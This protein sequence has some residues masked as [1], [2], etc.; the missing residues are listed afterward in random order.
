MAKEEHGR[1]HE[2]DYFRINTELTQTIYDFFLRSSA[3]T[4][5]YFSSIKAAAEVS[6]IPLTEEETP[7]PVSAYGRSKQQAE[8]YILSHLPGDPGRQRGPALTNLTAG[9]RNVFIL[10]PCMVHGPGRHGNLKS[11]FNYIRKGFPWPFFNLDNHRSYLS[12]EN[13]NYIIGEFLNPKPDIPVR[14]FGPLTRRHVLPSH[15]H[16]LSSRRHASHAPSGIYHLCDD[17]PLSATHIIAM[18]GEVLGRKPAAL[19]LPAWFIHFAA[20]T[21]TALHLPFNRMTVNKMTG[22]LIVSNSRIKHALKISALPVTAE[23]GMHDTL[24]SF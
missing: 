16:V 23:Q 6:D 13:L 22:N 18:M 7:H 9:R 24:E 20:V 1:S 2:H 12:M 8:Q 21:G 10:R 4:F 19:R 3:H 17:D 5:I 14:Y 15:R 11:L